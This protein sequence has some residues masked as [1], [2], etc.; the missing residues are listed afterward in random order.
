MEGPILLKLCLRDHVSVVQF[1]SDLL[2]EL[3]YTLTS[4][5]FFR[6]EPHHVRLLCVLSAK[7]SNVTKLYQSILL[8]IEHLGKNRLNTFIEYFFDFCDIVGLI[9]SQHAKRYVQAHRRH[10]AALMKPLRAL[11]DGRHTWHDTILQVILKLHVVQ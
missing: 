2:Y 4:L 3:N 10:K 8:L 9:Q 5:I 7:E 6:V 11:Q 1:L